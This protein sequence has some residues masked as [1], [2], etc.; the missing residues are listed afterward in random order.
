MRE[1][2]LLVLFALTFPLVA[3]VS[4]LPPQRFRN[5]ITEWGDRSS[6]AYQQF[7]EYRKKFKANEA[8]VLSWPGCTINDPR[9]EKVALGI[10]AQLAGY[11][12]DV[13]SGQ[14]AYWVLR[15]EVKLT[16]A[17]AL[18]RLRNVFIG[19]DDQATAVGFQLTESARMN[20]SEILTM[21]DG[22]LE[23]ADVDLAEVIYAGLGHNLYTMDKEGLESPFRM[24]PQ[25]MLLAFV[26]LLYTS[27]SPRDRQKS[28][29][30]SSA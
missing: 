14:R 21:L 6:L 19:Q 30:P 28:R 24:V 2:V 17:A 27:P 23:S 18:N 13:A 16:E 29:M 7:S 3:F 10:E 8:V 20:R 12:R 9:V 11:V 15:D 1:N 26:C 5:E 25:I 22:I 4:T